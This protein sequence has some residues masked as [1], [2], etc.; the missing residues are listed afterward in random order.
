[1]AGFIPSN[2]VADDL[3]IKPAVSLAPD[4]C[5]LFVLV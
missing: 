3:D 4:A 5:Q 2:E 1:M